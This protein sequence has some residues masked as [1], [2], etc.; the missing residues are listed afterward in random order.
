M[1]APPPP[2]EE[3][4]SR[5]LKR[6]RELDPHSSPYDKFRDLCALAYCAIAKQTAL[7]EVRAQEL[8]DRYMQIVGT[9]RDKNTV[10]AYPE[11]LAFAQIALSQGGCD[12]LGRLS[13]ELEILNSENGQ[14]FSPYPLARLMAQM[15]LGDAAALIKRDGYL[16]LCEPASGAGVMVLA[17]AD[18]LQEQGFNPS[19]TLLAEATDVAALCFHMSYIQLAMRGIPARVI[20]GDSLSREVIEW[21]WTPAAIPFMI[22]HPAMFAKQANEPATPASPA[23]PQDFSLI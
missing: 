1:P 18:V 11:L 15:T 16:T 21:S 8:E 17:A 9:Y 6:I 5:F 20:H 4:H 3:L 13:S 19:E 12:F 10:R 7:S 23:P 14:T 2:P 22:R